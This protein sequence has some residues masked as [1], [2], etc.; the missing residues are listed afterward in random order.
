MALLRKFCNLKTCDKRGTEVARSA[1]WPQEAVYLQHPGDASPTAM[2]IA[3]S[4]WQPS[5]C[6]QWLPSGR[7]PAS[8][9]TPSWERLTS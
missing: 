6:L 2:C 7:G 8:P 1:G 9:S 4:A 5:R 3:P